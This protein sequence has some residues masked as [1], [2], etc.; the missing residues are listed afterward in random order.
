MTLRQRHPRPNGHGRTSRTPASVAI[1]GGGFCGAT[2]AAR[3]LSD[4]AQSVREV[5]LIERDSSGGGGPAYCARDGAHLLNVPAAR[6]R[7]WPESPYAVVAW[8]RTRDTSIQADSFAPRHLYGEYLRDTLNS[9]VCRPATSTVFERIND[10]AI[11]IDPANDRMTI[12]LRNSSKVE[13]SRVVLALGNFD[14]ADPPI[15][16]SG[17]YRDQG[18][19]RDPWRSDALSKID[20]HD[21]V[22][23]IGTGLT[24]IDLAVSLDSHGHQGVIYAISRRGLLPQ[25]HRSPAQPPEY[26]L[27]RPD[28]DTWPRSTVELLRRLRSEIE[29][30]KQRGENWREVI[31]AIRPVTSHLWRR[32]GAVERGRFLRHA[33][34]LWD[35]HRHRTPPAPAATIDRMIAG[36]RLRIL[37]GRLVDLSRDGLRLVAAVRHRRDGAVTALAVG[38]VINS[39]GPECDITKVEH[40]LVRNLRKRGLIRPD[41]L[42]LGL[43]CDDYGAALD[44]RGMASEQLWALGSLRRGQLWES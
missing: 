39:T 29:H 6:L 3:L 25:P 10:E 4:P 28:V 15:T 12:H 24:M 33:R 1:I 2:L 13:V 23:V 8:A 37:A 30:A 44:E 31:N 18:Y 32:L 41:A 14:P 40:E 7:P 20:S 9:A 16:N 17:I 38:S 21:D 11:D 43:D 36:G 5:I 27:S 34:A 26:H 22:L 42:R 19:V 35:T